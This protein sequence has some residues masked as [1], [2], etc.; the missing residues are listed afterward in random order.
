MDMKIYAHIRSIFLVQEVKCRK[1]TIREGKVCGSL[2]R[3][4]N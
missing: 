1:L 3:G 4:Q 2:I